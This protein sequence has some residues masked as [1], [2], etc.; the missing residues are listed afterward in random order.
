[1]YAHVRTMTPVST[2]AILASV[3]MTLAFRSSH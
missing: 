1:M 3:L 2:R